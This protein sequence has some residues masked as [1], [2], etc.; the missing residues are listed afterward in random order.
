MTSKPAT[1]SR[2]VPQGSVLR[3]VLFTS[4]T[5]P[6]S[7]ICKKN[8]VYYHINADDTQLYVSFDPSIPGVLKRCIAEIRAWVLTHELKLTDD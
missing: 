2:G 1:L 5:L 3:P 7:S 8:G 4:Y 6:I